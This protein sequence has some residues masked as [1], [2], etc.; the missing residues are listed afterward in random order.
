MINPKI[1]DKHF[2]FDAFRFFRSVVDCSSQILVSKNELEIINDRDFLFYFFVMETKSERER[3]KQLFLASINQKLKSLNPG[4]ARSLRRTV[5]QLTNFGSEF[6]NYR[7][8][9][10]NKIPN[11]V[12]IGFCRVLQTIGYTVY[13]P[14][15]ADRYNEIAI[16]CIQETWKLGLSDVF[17]NTTFTKI[18]Y[19]PGQNIYNPEVVANAYHEA[20]NMVIKRMSFNDVIDYLHIHESSPITYA[21]ISK[22]NDLAV[23][24]TYSK[25][26]SAHKVLSTIVKH[27]DQIIFVD[28]RINKLKPTNDNFIDSPKSPEEV[29]NDSSISSPKHIPSAPLPSILSICPDYMNRRWTNDMGSVIPPLSPLVAHAADLP[30]TI[31][32]FVN[33]LPGLVNPISASD[34]F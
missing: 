6:K 25:F 34:R 18:V 26:A 28:S 11:T 29:S 13:L 5:H 4:D 1:P 19:H 2:E 31:D 3:A 27:N 23:I 10:L 9:K 15:E 7:T 16:M 8:I 33:R 14:R 17:N 32:L 12:I 22:S 30:S 21:A 24:V 20:L